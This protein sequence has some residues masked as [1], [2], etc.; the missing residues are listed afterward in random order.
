MEPKRQECF[1]CMDK[2]KKK[3][4]GLGLS[5]IMTSDKENILCK[6]YGGDN[7][8]INTAAATAD[9]YSGKCPYSNFSSCPYTS[10]RYPNSTCH[11][12]SAENENNSNSNNDSTLSDNL[13]VFEIYSDS[14]FRIMPTDIYTGIFLHVIKFHGETCE[15][16]M[17]FEYT[18]NGVE[19]IIN[20]IKFLIE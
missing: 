7:T 2:I 1:K 6:V 17:T 13:K 8:N 19:D 4:D 18:D 9:T 14:L 11:H 16:K 15:L 10:C 5:N 12:H 3:L 20:T